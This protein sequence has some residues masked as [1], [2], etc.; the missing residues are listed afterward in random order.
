M[1]VVVVMKEVAPCSKSDNKWMWKWESESEKQFPSCCHAVAMQKVKVNVRKWKWESAVAMQLPCWEAVSSLLPCCCHAKS[2]SKRE[3]VKL[4][5]CCC[6]AV[7]MLLPCCCHAVTRFC[8]HILSHRKRNCRATV[9]ML[10]P[11]SCNTGEQQPFAWAYV[12][13]STCFLPRR[14][15]NCR[16]IFCV[17]YV[18]NENFLMYLPHRKQN[19]R[20]TT[21]EVP[22][23]GR[24]IFSKIVSQC[25]D[26]SF[27]LDPC[28]L[29]PHNDRLLPT[30][31][32]A[33]QHKW[34]LTHA[35]K[36]WQ[37][38]DVQMDVNETTGGNWWQLVAT[39]GRKQIWPESHQ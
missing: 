22:L 15:R 6:Y 35:G 24:I 3:K 38:V 19:C 7:T 21:A 30:D 29:A 5:K 17:V 18:V 4:R 33:L 36:M 14:K 26:K 23:L 2:E 20:W 31:Y 37:V 11:C 9:A 16:W 12:G 27:K 32:Q 28:C 34:D 25:F 13:L 39:F 10:L 1:M 8:T